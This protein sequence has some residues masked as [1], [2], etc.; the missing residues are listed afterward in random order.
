MITSRLKH[1][2]KN[3]QF[4]DVATCDK[5][6]RPYAAPKFLL[7]VEEDKVYLADYVFG[8]TWYNLRENPLV[9]LTILDYDSLIAYQFNG[10]AYL[11]SEGEDYE[12]LKKDFQVKQMKSSVER[13]IKS[14][15]EEKLR[16]NFELIFPDKTGIIVVTVKEIVDID[17]TGQL[18]RDK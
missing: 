14:V 5:Q 6:C 2:F 10:E 11:V 1:F 9:S 15:H 3:A 13:V 16:R 8:K 17:P 18:T 4:V 7:K 12:A